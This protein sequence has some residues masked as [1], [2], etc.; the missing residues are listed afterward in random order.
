[1]LFKWEIEALWGGGSNRSNWT[2]SPCGIF[3]II[4]L[5]TFYMVTLM[6]K[7]IWE[8]RN[9]L[10]YMY[11]VR[12]LAAWDVVKFDLYSSRA[13]YTCLYCILD[14]STAYIILALLL[15][16]Y[17]LQQL[18]LFARWLYCRVDARSYYLRALPSLLSYH[19]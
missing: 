17:N 10:I 1:M 2:L 8:I 6:K 7:S 19:S 16:T 12:F 14:F 11:K 13:F 4:F 3:F 5:K 18:Y 9:A 15:I